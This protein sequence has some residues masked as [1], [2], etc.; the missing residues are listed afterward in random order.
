MLGNDKSHSHI[1]LCFSSRE[2]NAFSN[3]RTKTSARNSVDGPLI[4]T[5]R[6]F[7]GALGEM[8]DILQDCH[9]GVRVVCHDKVKTQVFL[10][11]DGPS[12]H[13]F[14]EVQMA[15]VCSQKM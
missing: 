5:I 14:E 6:W 7:S 2:S 4:E 1:S 12:K 8:L 10:S 3:G 9:V 15:A 11:A 13:G